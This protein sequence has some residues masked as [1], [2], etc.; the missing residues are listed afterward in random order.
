[1]IIIETGDKDQHFFAFFEQVSLSQHRQLAL[2]THANI[3][4][5]TSRNFR[6]NED[7]PLCSQRNEVRLWYHNV[8]PDGKYLLSLSVKVCSK[9]HLVSCKL[10]NVKRPLLYVDN[11]ILWLQI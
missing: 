11:I 10:K 7:L 5:K 6:E 8:K 9:W 3:S 4:S 1:M 2:L